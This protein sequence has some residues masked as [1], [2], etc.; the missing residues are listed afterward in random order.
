MTSS[1]KA[2]LNQSSLNFD[3]IVIGGSL[4]AI[5][6]A[7]LIKKRNP[8]LVVT[9]VEGAPSLGGN[10]LGVDVL[11]HH[12]ENGTHILQEIGDVEVDAII[13]SAVDGEHLVQLDSSVGDLA[14]TMKDGKVWE[15]TGYP[16]V[17]GQNPPLA[18]YIMRQI[19]DLAVSSPGVVQESV[20][21]RTL[22]FDSAVLERFGVE[23]KNRILLPIVQRL[24]GRTE[25]LSGFAMELCNLTRLRL[26]DELTWQAHIPRLDLRDRVAYPDQRSLPSAYRHNKKSLYSSKRGAIDFIDGL[27]EACRAIGVGVA[28]NTKVFNIDMA[29]KSVDLEI[30]GIKQKANFRHVMSCVGVTATKTLIAGTRPKDR[31]RLKYRIV[32]L[33]L[34]SPLKSDMCYFYSHD[35]D[36]VMF[37]VTNYAAFSRRIEDTRVTVEVIGADHHPDELL[38]REIEQELTRV[39]LIEEGSIKESICLN[40][41]YGYPIPTV[42]TFQQ[43]ELDDVMLSQYEQSGLVTCGLGVSGGLFFQNEILVDVV[44]RVRTI[45]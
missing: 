8:E 36:S 27:A 4:P 40:N 9:L 41:L 29:R 7:L 10:L 26:V 43:F 38:V 13:E 6:G 39:Q 12:F 35:V 37:R 11:G 28:L 23:A 2:S 17:L 19:E 3:V 18:S 31:H 14:G 15:L 34:K 5:V 21:F 20:N 30:D 33:V 45:F 16:D 1:L 24:F 44:S 25:D 22:N 32:H 42:E